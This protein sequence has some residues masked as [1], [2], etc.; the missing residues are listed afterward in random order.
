MISLFVYLNL[1][2]MCSKEIAEE[3]LELLEKLAKLEQAEKELAAMQDKQN[4]A[5]E[6]GITKEELITYMD[7][8]ECIDTQKIR[9]KDFIDS[10][11]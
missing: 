3:L 7:H 11:R 6:L 4:I 5:E 2:R 8:G 1:M 9:L 10:L